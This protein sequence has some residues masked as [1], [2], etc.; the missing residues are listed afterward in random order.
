MNIIVACYSHCI[1][2]I[3]HNSISAIGALRHSLQ[4]RLS[5]APGKNSDEI[6]LKLRTSTGVFTFGVDLFN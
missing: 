6:Y 4:D 5:K 2:L 1:N 3:L